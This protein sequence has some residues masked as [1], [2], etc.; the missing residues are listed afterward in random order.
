MITTGTDAYTIIEQYLRLAKGVI[1]QGMFMF[2][3]E[4]EGIHRTKMVV[5][6]DHDFLLFDWLCIWLWL[7]QA[8]I[9][10]LTIM[11]DRKQTMCSLC[12]CD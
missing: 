7:T 2:A 1:E 12:K 11:F 5:D 8:F 6:G 9:L 4:K 3:L 10:Y